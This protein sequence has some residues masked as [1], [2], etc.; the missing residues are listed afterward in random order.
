[1]NE[2]INLICFVVMGPDRINVTNTPTL[3]GT[4]S[5]PTQ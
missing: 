2:E 1:M 4:V 5:Q 3:F